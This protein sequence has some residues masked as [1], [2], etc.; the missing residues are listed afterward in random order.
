M[1]TITIVVPCWNEAARLRVGDF[2]DA[3]KAY[4][5]LTFVF[6]DDGS[7]DATAETLAFLARESPAIKALYLNKNSGKAE[8]VRAGINWALS[9]TSCEAVGFWDADLATPLEELPRF[10]TELE[11]DCS[12]EIVIGARWPHLGARIDRTLWRSFSSKIM[13][14]LIHWALGVN[15]FDTQCGAKLFRRATAQE[16]FSKPFISRW[17]FDVEIL[18]RLGP[19]RL[20]HHAV[21]IPL[22]NWIDQ[23]GS[24]L[25]STELPH[26]LHDLLKIRRTRPATLSLNV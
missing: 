26:L 12:R 11:R 13:K 22:S 17:L 3:I 19:T 5:Q 8:A 23:P 18:I 7:T 21:E 10:I 24:K 15:V 14:L 6:V 25:R 9:H 4:P 2:L 16:L 1:N 20:K